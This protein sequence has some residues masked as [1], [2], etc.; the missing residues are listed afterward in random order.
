LVDRAVDVFLPAGEVD[1]RREAVFHDIDEHV[2]LG[3]DDLEFSAEVVADSLDMDGH[4]RE[5][6]AG[7]R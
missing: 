3:L 5:L 6:D 2:V 7:G 1:R 4:T